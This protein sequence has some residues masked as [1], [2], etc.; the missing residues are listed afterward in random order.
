MQAATSWTHARHLLRR[1]GRGWP[2]AYVLG[3]QPFAHL[4]I[5]C[6]PA[7]LIPRWET[8]EYAVHLGRTLPHGLKM[9]DLC[10]GTGCI[11]LLLASM[12]RGASVQGVDISASAIA[13][14]RQNA[15]RNQHR[16]QSHVAFSQADV[17][18]MD[19]LSADFVVANPPYVSSYEVL[20][21][22][23]RVEPRLALVGDDVFYPPI[24]QLCRESRVR[25][26]VLEVGT[27]AQACTVSQLARKHDYAA[28]VWTDSSKQARAV[29]VFDAEFAMLHR[30]PLDG[31]SFPS[32]PETHGLRL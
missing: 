10:T 13:L 11:A 12:L 23:L 17:F 26:V 32:S 9:V 18:Q 20:D 5:K 16:L 3:W 4:D 22:S 19:K 2:L 21:R 24:L 27:P 29:A 1:R 30:G 31:S 6:S 14:A 7:A 15:T 25:G 8:E 28:S